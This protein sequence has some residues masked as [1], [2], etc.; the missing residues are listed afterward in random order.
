MAKIIRVVNTN[1]TLRNMSVG[2]TL[3]LPFKDVSP[4]TVRANVSG[5]RKHESL[6]FKVVQSTKDGKTIVTRIK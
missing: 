4:V 3:V 1:E 6:D 2:E 5:L